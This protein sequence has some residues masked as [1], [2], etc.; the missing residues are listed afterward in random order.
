[1]SRFRALN[2]LR[3]VRIAVGQCHGV[4]TSLGLLALNVRPLSAKIRSASFQSKAVVLFTMPG[5]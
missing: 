1:M 5:P 2:A 4:I 3:A